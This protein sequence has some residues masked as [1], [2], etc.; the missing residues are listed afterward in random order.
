MKIPGTFLE[1][2]TLLYFQYKDFRGKASG[3]EFKLINS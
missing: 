2:E 1:I 3:K